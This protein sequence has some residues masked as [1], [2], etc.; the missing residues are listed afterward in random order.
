MIL[1]DGP[2]LQ[3]HV[4]PGWNQE[5]VGKST[6]AEMQYRDADR[7]RQ[8]VRQGRAGGPWHAGH[9][10]RGHAARNALQLTAAKDARL[11]HMI[12]E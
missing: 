3:K 9:Q 11:V 4:E 10:D 6:G 1:G 2:A 7:P 12:G 5:I 8:A